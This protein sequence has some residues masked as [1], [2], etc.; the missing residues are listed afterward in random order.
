[1][2]SAKEKVSE[3]IT[4][5]SLRACNHLAFYDKYKSLITDAAE[6]ETRALLSREP[7]FEECTQ[8]VVQ[9][10]DIMK[11]IKAS[12]K[13]VATMGMFELEC[14]GAIDKLVCRARSVRDE[15]LQ[16]MLG[17]WSASQ[18]ELIKQFN[19]INEQCLNVPLDTRELMKSK[20]C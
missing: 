7:E 11:D 3:L 18:R 20:V 17:K 5:E 2:V 13:M 6:G 1:M 16:Y 9:Y 4:E 12:C 19:E 15:V 10:H 14:H 8:T